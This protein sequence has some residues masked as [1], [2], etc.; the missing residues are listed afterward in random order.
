MQ[1]TPGSGIGMQSWQVS[2]RQEMMS[3]SA[4]VWRCLFYLSFIQ[5]LLFELALIG[6]QTCCRGSCRLPEDDEGLCGPLLFMIQTTAIQFLLWQERNRHAAVLL[7]L[8]GILWEVCSQ[9]RTLLSFQTL[10]IG[11]RLGESF[12]SKRN[13]WSISLDQPPGWRI[14][15]GFACKGLCSG[16]LCKWFTEGVWFLGNSWDSLL[17]EKSIEMLHL[18]SHN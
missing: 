15:W 9:P 4:R 1:K 11:K 5:R 8:E 12:H 2:H 3:E 10:L 17:P 18:E 7:F 13:I 14:S 16:C 6:A